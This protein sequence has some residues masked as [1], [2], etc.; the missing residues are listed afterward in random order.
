[1]NLN[2]TLIA[3]VLSGASVLAHADAKKDLVQKVIQ[4]QQP[5]IENL[6]RQMTAQPAE[7][8]MQQAGAALGQVPAD[9]REATGKA[10]QAE[11]Q[12]Y[13]EA[14]SPIVRDKAIALAPTTLGPVLEEK[15]S[16]DELKQLVAWLESPVS[17]KYSQVSPEMTNALVRKLSE[18]G[19]PLVNGKIET[20]Q[21]AATKLVQDALA[22]A[23]GQGAASA[24]AK[25][26]K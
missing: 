23:K 16:E 21:K 9:K 25:K 11:A 12:K 19:A 26:S 6:A 17:R 14:A 10:L 7:Q 20:L 15:F 18:E 2:R 1:M 5:A 24:P 8:L 22:G 4:L 13:M 3:L